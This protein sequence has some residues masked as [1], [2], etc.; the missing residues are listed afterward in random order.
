MKANKL[1][2]VVGLVPSPTVAVVTTTTTELFLRHDEVVGL[3]P[4]PIRQ[5]T[6]DF[7]YLV[8]SIQ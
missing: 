6:D 5:P 4:S 8:N 1:D 7:T 2:E 3:V